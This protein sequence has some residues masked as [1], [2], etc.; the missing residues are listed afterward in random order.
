MDAPLLKN[1]DE[2]PTKEIIENVLG[3]STYLIYE[4]LIN[5]ITDNDLGLLPE[6]RYYNDGK[7]WLCKVQKKKKTVFWLSI[8]NGFF[9]TTFYFTEKNSSGIG[10]LDIDKQIKDD[11]WQNTNIGKLLPLTISISKGEQLSDV[12]QLIQYKNKII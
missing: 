9:K 2:F 10:E 5:I 1:Q 12:L 8:W 3:K 6:W 4:E 11:F 7:L